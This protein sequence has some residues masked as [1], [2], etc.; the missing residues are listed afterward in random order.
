MCFFKC[1][2]R[3]PTLSQRH[4]DLLVWSYPRPGYIFQVSSKSVQGFR[5][6]RASKFGLSHITL[7]S[8]FYNSLYYRTSR[9]KPWSLYLRSAPTA[10]KVSATDSLCAVQSTIDLPSGWL[11][12]YA[13]S[14]DI[15]KTS[16]RCSVSRM[17]KF[18]FPIYATFLLHIFNVFITRREAIASP[19]IGKALRRVLTA[20][21]RPAITPPKV[22][23]FG[24]NL[25]LCEPNV[26]GWPWRPWA[27]SVQ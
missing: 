20:F 24:W 6:P 1:S 15:F 25:E 16:I 8:R 5:S 12:R 22:N 3:P 23:R 27:R 11:K 21:T 10:S 14:R 18:T 19:S 9:D 2:P 4:L 7:A 26:E 13:D 17:S